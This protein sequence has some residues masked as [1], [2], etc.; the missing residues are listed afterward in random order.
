MTGLSQPSQ[1]AQNINVSK[2]Y[3]EA[4]LVDVHTLHRHAHMYMA[5]LNFEQSLIVPMQLCSHWEL[6]LDLLSLIK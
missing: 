1:N 3:F 4:H 2:L 6:E 5:S